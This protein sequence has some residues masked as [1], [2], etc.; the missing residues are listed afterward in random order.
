MPRPIIATT[1]ALLQSALAVAELSIFGRI[2]ARRGFPPMKSAGGSVSTGALLLLA[3]GLL[4][5]FASYGLWK[6]ACVGWWISLIVNVACVGL[7]AY[8]A[9]DDGDWDVY[10]VG[11]AFL[12]LAVMLL[13]P[14]VRRYYCAPAER[15]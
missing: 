8:A 5:A 12:A 3:L 4:S 1:A 9:F 10:L 7:F 15:R 11:G 13:V 14:Q 6:R 2:V